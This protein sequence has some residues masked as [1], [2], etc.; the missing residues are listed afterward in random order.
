MRTLI[1]GIGALAMVLGSA[2]SCGASASFEREEGS[3]EGGGITGSAGP[4]SGGQEDDAT[5]TPI[6]PAG[7]E[8]GPGVEDGGGGKKAGPKYEGGFGSAGPL[9]SCHEAA[10]SAP[11]E[12]CGVV[13]S[14]VPGFACPTKYIAKG[15]CPSSGLIGC[16]ITKVTVGAYESEDGACYYSALAAELAEAVCTGGA[17]TWV[18]KSP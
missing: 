3:G 9:V 10:G 5:V 13:S 11:L 16:C 6:S 8:G 4:P 12:I 15:P 1:L 17:V 2:A 7:T 14:N 18:T